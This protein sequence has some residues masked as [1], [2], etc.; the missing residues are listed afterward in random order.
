MAKVLKSHYLRSLNPIMM[1]ENLTAS[2][3]RL[4][5]KMACITIFVLKEDFFQ[6]NILRTYTRR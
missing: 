3:M 5:I 6:E 4:Y 1:I 2:Y